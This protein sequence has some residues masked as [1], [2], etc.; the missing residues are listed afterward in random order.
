M[1][2]KMH[3]LVA[4]GLALIA[5]AAPALA[6]EWPSKPVKLIV[7]F[8]PGGPVDTTARVIADKLSLALKQPV[9][10]DNKP[11]ANGVIGSALLAKSAPDGYTLMMGASTMTIQVNLIKNL[12]FDADKDIEKIA[13]IGQAPMV[14]LVSSQSKVNT[15]AD[16]VALGKSNPGA[17]SYANPSHGSSTH[18]A[19]ELFK[20]RSGTDFL[21]VLYKGGAQAETDLLGGHVTM[22]FA[23]TSSLAHVRGGRMRALAVTTAQRSRSAPEIPTLAESGFPGFDVSTWYGIMG[24]AGMPKELVTRINAEVNKILAMPDVQE[25]LKKSA[26]EPSP[27]TPAQFA[28]FMLNDQVKWAKVIKDAKIPAEQ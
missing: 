27:W 11:G 20:Q 18:L 23:G 24:P 17:L 3:C 12:P 21:N 10:V 2:M 9:V 8:A 28:T 19:A 1:K 25:Q 26:V 5:A 16:L 4:T 22:M 6:Q 14:L 7:G 15:V 13:I